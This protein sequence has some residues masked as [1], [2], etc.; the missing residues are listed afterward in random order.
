[1]EIC[2]VCGREYDPATDSN[3]EENCEEQLA[4]NVN[5]E[6]QADQ[7]LKRLLEGL[8]KK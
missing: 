5:I 8:L 2:L 4:D 6:V 7:T 3:H 1:M